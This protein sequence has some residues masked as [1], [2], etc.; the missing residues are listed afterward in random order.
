MCAFA[1]VP[2]ATADFLVGGMMWFAIYILYRDDQVLFIPQTCLVALVTTIG[3]CSEP[4]VSR[5]LDRLE[6]KCVWAATARQ[7][8]YFKSK[9][10]VGHTTTRLNLL[11]HQTMVRL[12][13][14]LNLPASMLAELQALDPAMAAAPSSSRAQQAAAQAVGVPSA[15]AAAAVAASAVAAATSSMP[16]P[17]AAAIAAAIPVNLPVQLP[18]VILTEAELHVTR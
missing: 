18:V 2:A 11:S 15:A 4:H 9:G 5:S 13:Q 16:P 6:P 10:V 14:A 17:H 12:A 7:L 3:L 1:A 8:A